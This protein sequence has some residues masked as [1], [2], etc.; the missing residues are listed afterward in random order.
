MALLDG[1]VQPKRY[2]I[3]SANGVTQSA[4]N[5]RRVYRAD[6]L[7]HT[8][9]TGENQRQ[10]A[11]SSKRMQDTTRCK[12]GRCMTTKRK[13]SPKTCF[14]VFE[15]QNDNFFNEASAYADIKHRLLSYEALTFVRMKR[16]AN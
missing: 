13:A 15:A 7:R 4:S 10:F 6:V 9:V 1:L 8:T 12:S 16:S 14:F 11:R 2:S 5:R 3:V